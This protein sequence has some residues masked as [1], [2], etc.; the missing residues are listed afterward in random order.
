MTTAEL[1][2]SC[3]P[4]ALDRIL[5]SLTTPGLHALWDRLIEEA[6]IPPAKPRERLRWH[7]QRERRQRFK[8]Y[9]ATLSVAELGQLYSRTAAGED[10]DQIMPTPRG[11]GHPQEGRHVKSNRSRTG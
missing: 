6:D 10:I 2:R 1:L 5:A 8:D 9:T 7:V 11:V 4:E 3:T